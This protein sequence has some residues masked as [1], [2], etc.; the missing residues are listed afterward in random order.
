MKSLFDARQSLRQ[1]FRRGNGVYLR[2]GHQR[3]FAEG[4]LMNDRE[5]REIY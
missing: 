5:W 1:S 4:H 2:T 3:K